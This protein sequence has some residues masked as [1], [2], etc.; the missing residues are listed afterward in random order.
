M[1]IYIEMH[2]RSIYYAVHF[3]AYIVHQ[4]LYIGPKNG[5]TYCTVDEVF[6]NTPMCINS[7]SSETGQHVGRRGRGTHE[8]AL[9]SRRLLDNDSQCRGSLAEEVFHKGGICIHIDLAL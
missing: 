8:S 9:Q 7:G 5:Y 3:Y 2:I 6:R 1:N 4:Y